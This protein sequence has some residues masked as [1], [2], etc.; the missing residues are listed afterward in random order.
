MVGLPYPDKRDPELRQKMDYLD[1]TNP[2]SRGRAGREFYQNICMRA[3]NQSIGR[4]IRHAKDYSS[5]LLVDQRYGDNHVI[6]LLPRWI[7]QRVIRPSS[8]GEVVVSL[9]RFYSAMQ[10]QTGPEE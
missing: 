8:F 4:S 1:A 3:V 2:D 7:S 6:G 9:R 5:I 10:S